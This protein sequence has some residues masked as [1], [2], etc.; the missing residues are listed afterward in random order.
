[1]VESTA[2][3]STLQ[4]L[5]LQS[6]SQRVLKFFPF[7]SISWTL[8]SF[9][10]SSALL[11]HSLSSST[12]ASPFEAARMLMQAA[13]TYSAPNFTQQMYYMCKASTSENRLQR[14]KIT[15]LP[16]MNGMIRTTLPAQLL[17]QVPF[18]AFKFLLFE[19]FTE[20]IY[21]SGLGTNRNDRSQYSR[22]EQLATVSVSGFLTGALLAG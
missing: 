6:V 2:I 15:D 18:T 1:M 16:P 5:L 14:V 21:S 11:T 19:K 8:S 4:V 12:F 20:G 17:R 13:P 9:L 3:L 10:P 7:S 22:A